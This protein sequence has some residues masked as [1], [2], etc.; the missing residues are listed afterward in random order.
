MVEG[1]AMPDAA[2]LIAPMLGFKSALPFAERFSRILGGVG[3][4]SRPA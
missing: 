1:A 3:D 4:S 2:V